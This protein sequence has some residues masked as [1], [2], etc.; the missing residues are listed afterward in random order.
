MAVRLRPVAEIQSPH[1][2]LGCR[3][4]GGAAPGLRL[5]AIRFAQ[6]TLRC[7]VFWP[8][9]ITPSARCAHYGRTYAAS[10]ITKHAG[11][12][13]GQKPCASRR[14]TVAPAPPRPRASQ[15]WAW[16]CTE[17]HP[18]AGKAP[19]AAWAGRI[20]AAEKHSVAG[21]SRT[22]ALRAL[23]CGRLFERSEHSERSEFGHGPG[24]RASQGTLS[25]A[26]GKPPEPCPGRARRLA[27]AADG[28]C[29][30]RTDTNRRNGPQAEACCRRHALRDAMEQVR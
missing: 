11:T 9:C 14:R 19:G 22:R 3:P 17:K 2:V 13:A 23:T 28:A 29:E 12:H 8:R 16:A 21:R 30:L 10:Q 6:G 4:E 7:S 1:S 20:G 26:K 18:L 27:G 15:Q 5:L 25:K 24:T